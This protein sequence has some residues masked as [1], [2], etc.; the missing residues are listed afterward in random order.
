MKNNVEK[1]ISGVNKLCSTVSLTLG[2]KGKNVVIN[3][4]GK[5]LITNDGVKYL[6][7]NN[8]EIKPKSG[9]YLTKEQ[10]DAAN[11]SNVKIVMFN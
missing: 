9:Y 10:C 6:T 5:P 3:N 8:R 7:K 1:L 2:P 11:L 4:N